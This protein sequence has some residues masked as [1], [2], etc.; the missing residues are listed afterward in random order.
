MSFQRANFPVTLKGK[1]AARAFLA[2]SVIGDR[3]GGW[4]VAHVDEQVR[5]IH[6]A[7]YPSEPMGADDA[8]PAGAILGDAVRLG[9]AGLVLA[10]PSSSQSE[11]A[12]RGRLT[13][14]LARVAES[15]DVTVVDHLLFTGGHCV[16][17]RGVGLL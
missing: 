3:S 13:R 8:L 9:S 15:V 4:W 10:S 12:T 5:C 17:L 11:L 7:R 1:D 14:E 16:S 6:L 2:P